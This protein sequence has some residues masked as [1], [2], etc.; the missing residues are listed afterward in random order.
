MMEVNRCSDRYGTMG[1]GDVIFIPVGDYPRVQ[2]VKTAHIAQ[3]LT[4]SKELDCVF[5]KLAVFDDFI[6]NVDRVIE[7]DRPCRFASVPNL[8]Q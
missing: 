7:K 2:F 4:Q 6:P 3:G 1:S 5:C 8:V